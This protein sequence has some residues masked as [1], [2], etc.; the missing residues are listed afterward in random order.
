VAKR[1]K[2]TTKTTKKA[3]AGP[4]LSYQV[5]Q[6]GGPAYIPELVMDELSGVDSSPIYDAIELCLGL[7]EEVRH[8]KSP[9]MNALADRCEAALADADDQVQYIDGAVDFLMGEAEIELREQVE[10]ATA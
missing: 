3:A 9:A 10:V 6:R 8:G 7:I 2:T 1:T 5:T 4:K